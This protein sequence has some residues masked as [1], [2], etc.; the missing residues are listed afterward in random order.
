MVSSAA[1][2][3]DV[4]AAACVLVSAASWAVVSAATCTVV[5]TTICVDFR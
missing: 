3:R 5:S 2:W 1:H 4:N